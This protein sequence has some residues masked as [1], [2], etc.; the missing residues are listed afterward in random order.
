MSK[1]LRFE[2]VVVGGGS[3]GT[4]LAARL[5]E[6]ASKSVLLLEAGPTFRPNEA[7][8]SVRDASNL[9]PDPE[10]LWDDNAARP[11]NSPFE[12]R[13]RVLGGGS[14]INATNFSP[15][16]SLRFCALDGT[17]PCRLVLR[18]RPAVLQE[19]GDQQLRG[20]AAAWAFGAGARSPV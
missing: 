5:S 10:L 2:C 14:S 15:G 1:F 6:D 18:G 20:P 11:P 9:A 7:P 12:L 3:A 13:A 4:V 16:V 8:Q 17:R 19:D